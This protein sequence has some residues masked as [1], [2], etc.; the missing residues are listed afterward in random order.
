[1]DKTMERMEENCCG[2]KLHFLNLVIDFSVVAYY[3][4]QT[5]QS[6]PQSCSKYFETGKKVHVF[7]SWGDLV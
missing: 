7:Y 1:M 2:I 3:P 4:Y 6:Q 5:R